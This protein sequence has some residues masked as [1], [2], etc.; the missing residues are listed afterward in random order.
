MFGVGVACG[1]GVV[2][3]ANMAQICLLTDNTRSTDDFADLY[4][5]DFALKL[6]LC[7]GSHTKLLYTNKGV[8]FSYYLH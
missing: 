2:G 4:S 6:D 3:G 5:P 1:F 8:C 7:Q